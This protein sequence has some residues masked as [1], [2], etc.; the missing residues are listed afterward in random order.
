MSMIA[1]HIEPEL[2]DRLRTYP[3][4]AITGPRQAGKTTLAKTIIAHWDKEAIYL[5][6][7]LP[8]DLA[9][10]TH[11]ELYLKENED[12]LVV[13]DEVQRKPELFPLL[14]ALVDQ[15]RVAGRFLILGSASPEMLRQSSE[16][17]AGRISYLELTPFHLAELPDIPIKTHWLRGG[18]PPALLTNTDVQAFRWLEDFS[19]TFIERD[20]PQFGLS[21]PAQTLQNLCL[22]LTGVHGNLLNHSS[23]ANSLGVSMPTLK[24]YLEYLER[25]YFIRMLPPWFANVSKRVVKSPK[26]FY[27]DS[28]VLHSFAGI[29][30]TQQLFGNRLVG[31]SWE[32]Y[33]IQQIIA[34]LP[35]RVSPYFYRTSNGAEIDLVLVKGTQPWR[36]IEVKF[37]DQP[38]L[39][40]GNH[41][42]LD[43]LGAPLNL[44]ITLH[45]EDYPLA[46]NIRVCGVR[47]AAKYLVEE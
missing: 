11:A 22:M 10:L 3:V 31:A 47:E 16:T 7:E 45:P 34:N 17:L 37:G 38:T 44:V 43:D 9:R 27:R 13:I 32:G 14:R 39:S 29:G 2:W 41:S 6:L 30:D 19:I 36:T 12:R 42:A 40:K 20:L 8:S 25:A 23:L 33:V 35:P 15:N 24:R 26:V 18:F 5:D 21:A 46:E 28:G 1:R 4:V